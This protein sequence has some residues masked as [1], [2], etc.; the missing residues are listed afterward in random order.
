MQL[1][2]FRYRNAGYFR[3]YTEYSLT[4]FSLSSYISQA[5]DEGEIVFANFQILAPLGCQGWVV[6]PQNM[7]EKIS[8]HPK[9][10]AWEGRRR[11]TLEKTTEN[12]IQFRSLWI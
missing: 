3:N 1:S 8:L 12:K 9:V 10:H 5:M 4:V 6:N 11:S 7:K 2:S